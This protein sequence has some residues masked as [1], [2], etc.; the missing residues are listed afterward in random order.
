MNMAR[1]CHKSTAKY[2]S[3][4]VDYSGVWRE[5]G[6]IIVERLRAPTG[7]GIQSY[8]KICVRKEIPWKRWNNPVSIT[9]W[10]IWGTWMIKWTKKDIPRHGT[11]WVSTDR[12]SV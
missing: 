9:L 2:I 3:G 12:Y 8:G 6:L 10:C 11:Q 5:K 7:D 1:Y 4:N